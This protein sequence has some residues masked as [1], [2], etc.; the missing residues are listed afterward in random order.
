MISPRDTGDARPGGAILILGR[1]PRPGACKTRLEPLLGP[2]GCAALQAALLRHTAAWASRSRRSAWIA[3][4]PPD[5]GAEI[6]RHV[7]ASVRCFPQRGTDLGS[8]LRNAVAHVTAAHDG[9][10]AVVGTDAPTVGIPHLE[11]LEQALAHGADVSLLAA[12]DGGYAAIALAR[13]TP[14]AFALPPAAWG[15]PD[16]LALTVAALRRARMSVATLP[17]VHDLDIPAD[18]ARLVADPACPVA[19]RDVLRPAIEVA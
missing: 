19:I 8:R 3:F 18:A 13:T 7:P 16:V 6:A 12:H 15:G 11:A 1:A 4:D 14:E 9:P 17:P 10:V 2:S 5:A